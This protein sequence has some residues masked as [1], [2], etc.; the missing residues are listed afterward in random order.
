MKIDILIPTYQRAEALLPNLSHLLTLVRGTGCESRC[1]IIVSDNAST[2]AT[3]SIVAKF[4]AERKCAELIKYRRN[5]QNLGLEKN[6]VKC[7]E[8]ATADFVLWCGDDDFIAD[9]YLEFLLTKID[10][11]PRLGCV[12]PGLASLHQDGSLHSGRIAPYDIKEFPNG[13]ESV[14]QCSHLA[15]QMS[16]ILLRRQGLLEAYLKSPQYRNPYLFIYM[17]SD[18]M[19]KYDTIYAPKFRTA[20]TVFNA[21][22]WSYNKVGLL[23]EVFKNYF[24]LHGILSK[25]QIDNLLLKFMVMHSYRLAF[26]PLNFSLLLRQYIT[27][28][29]ITGLTLSF[30]RRV[31]ILFG[32]EIVASLV[33]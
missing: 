21:K 30:K 3:E 18:R 24:A 33:K 29:S 15:H 26:R 22:D 23:D 19:L 28:L 14:L 25:R 27:L 17:A 1:R 4:V 8:A 2:D 20:V 12:L 11:N 31:S 9:G 7:L 16:G 5:E 13:Y 6:A 32:K 10:E